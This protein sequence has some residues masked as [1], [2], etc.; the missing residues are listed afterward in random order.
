MNVIGKAIGVVIVV[1]VIVGFKLWSKSSSYNNVKN[2][3]L[4]F[5]E[6]IA[7]CESM[8]TGHFDTCFDNSYNMDG[9]R[10]SGGLDHEAFIQCMNNMSRN[11]L[12]ALNH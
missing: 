12:L 1:R 6:G 11:E 8:L 9:R 5:C 4:T 2:Q 7:K 10:H 3:M